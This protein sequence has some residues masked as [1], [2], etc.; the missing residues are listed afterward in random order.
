MK[1]YDYII[2]PYFKRSALKVKAGIGQQMSLEQQ[3]QVFQS[4]IRRAKDT[5]WGKKYDYNQIQTVGD[6]KQAVP[7]QTY[8]SLKPDLE[9]IMAGEQNVLWS[10]PIRW[11]AKSSGT[12]SNKSKFIPVSQEALWEGHYKGA[13]DVQKLFCL[14]NPNTT[15]YSGKGLVIGGSYEIS[16]LSPKVRYG[17][18]SAVLM[19]NLPFLGRILRTP[20]QA[21]MLL[22]DWE[23]KVEQT[24]QLIIKQN[25]TQIAGVPTWNLVL[26]KRVLEITGKQNIAEI[27]PN[28]QLYLHGGVSFVPYEAQFKTMIQKEKM[29]YWENYNASEGFF[30]FQDHPYRRDMLLMTNH[31]IFYEFMPLD[32][33]H[34][35]HPKTLQLHEISPNTNY[36]LVV[37]TNAG[38]WRYQMGDTIKF[39]T[40][41]PYRIV[42]TGRT[43]HFINAFG[44]ELMIENSDYALAQ[45]CAKTGLKVVEY[46]AAPVYFST[47][48]NGTHEW[49]I[50]FDTTPSPQKLQTFTHLLDQHLQ[51]VNSDYEA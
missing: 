40:T 46:T 22:K 12:T 13:A 39:T 45:T 47:G 24:A 25:I 14:A 1:L 5:V 9:R 7:L 35:P 21:I 10:S 31:G 19:A 49:L 8:D 37:S 44:E 23:E 50:E 2:P 20:P 33:L 17:D 42:V 16:H 4:L 6:F 30:A 48:N 38:L 3:Q 15:I 28:L 34:L 18:L 11:F 27:W 32:Q 26:M 29:Q 43:K 51:Q 41:N 36:A